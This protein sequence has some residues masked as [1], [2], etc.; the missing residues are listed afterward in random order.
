[1]DM[2]TT[3]YAGPLPV[4]DSESTPYWAGLKAHKLMLQRCASTGEFLF[5]PVTFCPGTLEKPEWAEASGK[6]E[7]FSWIVVRHPVPRDIYADKVPYVVALVTLDEGCRMTANIVDIAPEDMKA[8]MKVE[9]AFNPV[10][11]DITLPA[12]RPIAG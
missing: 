2:P 12:F 8:G 6:G 3:A 10:T 5:P 9:I 11:A 7:V 4:P 1:M